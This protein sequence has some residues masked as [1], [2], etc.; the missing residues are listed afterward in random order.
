MASYDSADAANCLSSE[1]MI[2]H[3]HN[4]TRHATRWQSTSACSY[5]SSLAALDA[6]PVPVIAAVHGACIGGGV[7]LVCAADVR[8]A[9]ADASFVVK[10]G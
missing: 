3:I 1:T 9:S 2:C 4:V 5:Q 6:C 8:L 10:V 7:D